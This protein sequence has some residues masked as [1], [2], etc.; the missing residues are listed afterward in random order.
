MLSKELLAE[1]GEIVQADYQ[2]QLSPEELFDVARTLTSFY[3]ELIYG[4]E[5]EEIGNTSEQE[6]NAN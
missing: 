3:G 4:K 2:T 6:R 5:V 1:L